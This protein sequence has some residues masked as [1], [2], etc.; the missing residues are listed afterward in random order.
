MAVLFEHPVHAMVRDELSA[1]IAQTNTS[2]DEMGIVL[3]QISARL[4]SGM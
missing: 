3:I 2:I 4:S 1:A